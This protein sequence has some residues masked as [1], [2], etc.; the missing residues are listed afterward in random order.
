MTTASKVVKI[1][2]KQ[3]G[4]CES[5]ANS[6]RQ[7]Y[8][9]DYGW[10]GTF[11]CGQFVWWCGWK[12]SGKNQ[13]KNPIAKSAS[14]AY[15]QEETVARGGKWVMKK[16]SSSSTRRAALSKYKPGDIVSFDFG[17]YDCV[18]DHT[19]IVDHVDGNYVVCIEGNTSKSGSQ[20]N[21]G[22]VCKKK[23][24]Y[25]EICSAVRPAYEEEK[26]KNDRIYSKAKECS[27]KAGTAYK[28]RAYPSG[29]PKKAYKKALN[30]A[31]P[32]R[33]SWGQQTRKGASCDVFVGTVIRSS[34]VDKKFP[35]GLDEVYPYIKSSRG[36]KKWK[37]KRNPKKKNLKPGD[38]I[39][40]I[41]DS[42]AGHISIYLG[43]NKVANAHYYGKSYPVIE[44]YSSKVRSASGCRRFYRFRPRG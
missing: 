13:S 7:K 22:M 5:P 43:N 36:K 30:D 6:N 20:S 39:Y 42:G 37:R 18:R 8:G 26:T 33:S 9:R 15:I 40:Q 28:K 1:A 41:F 32:N 4:V 25:T 17:T 34:G 12:A 24:Y 35:R 2:R 44:K 29:K 3:I 31:Y 38:V 19:G 23:R 10:N 27:Y 11:W 21:G 14:A 16:T